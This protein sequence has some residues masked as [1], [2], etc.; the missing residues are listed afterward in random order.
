MLA[1]FWM[2][3]QID[4][5]ICTCKLSYI[6]EWLGLVSLYFETVLSNSLIKSHLSLAVDQHI[7]RM[8]STGVSLQWHYIISLRTKFKRTNVSLKDTDSFV[9]FHKHTMFKGD[10]VPVLGICVTGF[11]VK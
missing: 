9:N 5:P 6:C 3:L 10:I 8:R 4:C 11:S 7:E 1:H 2:F